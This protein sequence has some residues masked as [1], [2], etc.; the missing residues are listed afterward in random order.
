MPRPSVQIP[1]VLATIALL[2]AACTDS[3]T[4][5]DGLTCDSEYPRLSPGGSVS[6]TIASTDRPLDDGTFYDAYSMPVDEAGTVTIRMTSSEVDSFLFLLN[7]TEQFLQLD[8][9]SGGGE[10]GEDA[11]IVWEVT[12]A[13]YVVIANTAVPDSGAYVLSAE[14]D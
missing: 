3:A 2:S 12:R 8:D 9:D 11:E 6:G 13:C 7:A 1:A 14:L 10:A 5:P 4:G